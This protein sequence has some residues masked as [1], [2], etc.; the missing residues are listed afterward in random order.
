[1]SVIEGEFGPIRPISPIEQ[2]ANPGEAPDLEN[3]DGLESLR[4][5]LGLEGPI[6][7]DAEAEEGVVVDHGVVGAE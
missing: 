2:P 6:G 3:S 7:V 5:E 4:G 1:M